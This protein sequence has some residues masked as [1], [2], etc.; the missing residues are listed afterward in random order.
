MSER[1][2][3]F[4]NVLIGFFAMLVPVGIVHFRRVRKEGINE[5]RLKDLENDNLKIRAE[6]EKE[7]KELRENY[8][9]LDECFMDFSKDYQTKLD[10]LIENQSK[11]YASVAKIEGYIFGLEKKK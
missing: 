2:T 11:T 10:K 8:K 1:L 6:M 7:V 3:T 5:Q 4:L 9:E